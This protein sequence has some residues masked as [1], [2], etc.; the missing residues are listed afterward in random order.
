ML[1]RRFRAVRLDLADQW[2]TSA[3]VHGSEFGLTPWNAREAL[4]TVFIPKAPYW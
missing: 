4:G 1:L 2:L 3:M